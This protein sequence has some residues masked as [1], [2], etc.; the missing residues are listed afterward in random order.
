MKSLYQYY[1]IIIGAIRTEGTYVHPTYYVSLYLLA[2]IA[3][4]YL[5]LCSL[6][7]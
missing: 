5:L 6:L 3:R 7:I 1:Y 2:V 4:S